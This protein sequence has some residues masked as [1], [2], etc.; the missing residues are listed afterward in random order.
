MQIRNLMKQR[1]SCIPSL[2]YFIVILILIQ[3]K[4]EIVKQTGTIIDGNPRLVLNP[5]ISMLVV[6]P[7]TNTDIEKEYREFIRNTWKKTLPENTKL[8]FFLGIK[9]HYRWELDQID[10]EIAEF[11]DIIKLNFK[12]SYKDLSLK[13]AMIYQWIYESSQNTYPNLKWIFKT[14]TD[15]WFNPTGFFSIIKNLPSERLWIGS[16]NTEAGVLRRGAWANPDY[17]SIKYPHYN[18]GAGYGLTID[19]VSWIGENFKLGMLKIMPNEDALVG[20]WLAGLNVRIIDTPYI[21]PQIGR[22]G[23]KLDSP[24]ANKC[25]KKAFLIHNMSLKGL[26]DSFVRYKKCGTTC[27]KEC[28][29]TTDD[30]KQYYK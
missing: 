27:A 21:L 5:G 8:L 3:Y 6:I 30:I 13:M 22:H 18:A 17:T 9:G 1:F 11:G 24:W 7:I 12:E 29:I 15:V 23:K 2:F 25:S 28:D 14:D 4:A 10:D 26:K 20:I 16:M 19:I